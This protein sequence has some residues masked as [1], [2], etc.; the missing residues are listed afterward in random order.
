MGIQVGFGRALEQFRSRC[1]VPGAQKV[2]FHAEKVYFPVIMGVVDVAKVPKASFLS[3]K[4][5]FL[6]AWW[7]YGGREWFLVVYKWHPS[8]HWSNFGCNP[9]AQEL[10]K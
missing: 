9:A 2:G 3:M 5:N 1:G 7:E 6:G 8:G 4:I 10:R